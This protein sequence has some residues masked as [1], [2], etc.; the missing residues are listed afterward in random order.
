MSTAPQTHRTKMGLPAAADCSVLGFRLSQVDDG[1]ATQMICDWAMRAESRVVLAANVHMVMSA[2]D[3]SELR[4]LLNTADLAV[5]DGRPLVWALR[6]LGKKATHVRGTDLTLRVCEVAQSAKL[7]MGLY[8]STPQTL[9]VL[10]ETLARTYPSLQLAFAASPPFRELSEAEDK[11]ML[12]SIIRSGA[13]ILLVGLGCPKQERWMLQR[14]GDLPC[15]MMG[16]GAAFDFVAGTIPQAPRWMQR[17][18]L[19]WVFR[20]ATDPRRLWRRYLNHNPRFVVL[21]GAQCAGRH[22][23]RLSRKRA[24]TPG[25]N[26]GDEEERDP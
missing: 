3:D 2:W 18:G 11:A 15:V 19:E 6:L 22:F 8:G 1:Q 21:A 4:V 17:V 13:R 14:R 26:P 9:A 5:Q 25:V 12:D 10:R 7:P 20:L 23:R 24:A 16:V